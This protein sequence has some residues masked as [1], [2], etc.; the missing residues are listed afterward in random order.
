MELGSGYQVIARLTK[1]NDSTLFAR[2][3]LPYIDIGWIGRF[4]ESRKA[5]SRGD[6]ALDS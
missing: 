6:S 2:Q 4:L 5:R 1:T 3:S